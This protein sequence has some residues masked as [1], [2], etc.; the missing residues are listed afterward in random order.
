MRLLSFIPLKVWFALAALV[1]LFGVN[2]FAFKRGADFARTE[3][4]IET[5]AANIRALIDAQETIEQLLI[6]RS[7]RDATILRLQNE[8]SSD[9]NAGSIAIGVDSVRRL[10]Q[11]K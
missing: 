1:L 8:A 3:I 4:Q 5:D 7:V 10:N 6:G 11:I 2:Y 9:A